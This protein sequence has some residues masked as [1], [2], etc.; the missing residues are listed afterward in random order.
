MQD[1]RAALRH[2]IPGVRE[3]VIDGV[4]IELREGC[5]GD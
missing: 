2:E 5:G 4:T 1:Y 3:I